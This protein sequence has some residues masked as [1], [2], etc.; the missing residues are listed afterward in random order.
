MQKKVRN[1]NLAL[2]DELKTRID[3]AKQKIDAVK[4]SEKDLLNIF[5]TASRFADKLDSEFRNGT[6]LSNV[7]SK[8]IDRTS[9]LAKQ[10]GIDV[11]SLS[12]VKQVLALQQELEKAMMKAESTLK[13][14]RSL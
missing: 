14:Y 10:L 2:V 11:N 7:I 1:I 4:K 8:S 6:S 5:D 3:E 13:A 12:E 9:T